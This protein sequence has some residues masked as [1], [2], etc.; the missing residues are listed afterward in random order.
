MMLLALLVAPSAVQPAP[1]R[2]FR[3]WT[4]GCDNGGICQ[5]V[6]LAPA[7]A[8]PGDWWN[9]HL[10][11]GPAAEAQPAL[12]LEIGEGESAPAALAADG[13]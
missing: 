11:R 3:D 6:S 12:A 13:K 7:S 5:A 1:P 9:L 8:E 2:L 4:V 10:A